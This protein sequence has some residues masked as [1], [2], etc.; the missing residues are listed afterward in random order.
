MNKRG[1]YKIKRRMLS[2]VMA[3]VMVLSAVDVSG[4]RG[5]VA[6][7]AD[8]AQ[9]EQEKEVEIREEEANEDFGGFGDLFG[10][11]DD[12]TTGYENGFAVDE[13]GNTVYQPAVLT[14]D[15][16]DVDGDDNYDEVYE[17]SNAG[18]LY[19]FANETNEKSG[20]NYNVVLTSDIVINENVLVDGVLAEDT[21]SFRKWTPICH[22]GLEYAGVFDGKGHTISGIYCANVSEEFQYGIGVFGTIN[23]SGTV[24]NLGVIDSY[25][26]D[27]YEMGAGTGAIVGCN[28]GNII[29]CYNTGVV[30]GETTKQGGICGYNYS[31]NIINCYNKGSVTGGYEHVSIGGICGRNK[32]SITDSYNTGNIVSS[33][34]E[35]KIGGVCGETN[36]SIIRC[37]NIGNVTGSG[38][39][40]IGGVV[41][42]CYD[43]GKIRNSYNTG[44]I[45]TSNIYACVGGV[46]GGGNNNALVENCYNT[47]EVTD[48]EGTTRNVVNFAST[49][50]NCYYLSDT[51]T[52]DEDG[53][54]AKNEKEFAGG[55]VA[56][57]LQGDQ[58]EEVWGQTLGTDSYPVLGGD[59]VYK[60]GTYNGCI[61]NPGEAVSYEYSNTKN[62]IYGD[63]HIDIDNDGK[64]D[65]CDAVIDG[66]GAKLAG[67]SLSLAGNIGVN[68]YMELS[69]DIV[70]DESAYMNFTLP[71]GTTSKVYVSGTHEDGTTATTDTTVK[72]NTTYYVFTCE[73]TAK[74][75]TA[76]IQAQMIG[77]N[78]EKK[79]KVYTYTVK[80]YADYILSH[81]SADEGDVSKA[82][83]QL[84]K[85][86][87][88]YG[89]AAQKYFGYKTDKLASDGLELP[90]TVFDDTVIMNNITNDANKASVTYYNT[91]DKITF[92]SAYLSLNS[93]TDLCVYVQLAEDVT[94]NENTFGIWCN[95]DQ[96]S[97]DQYEVTKVNE[98]NCYKITLHGMKASQLQEKYIFY[99]ELSDTETAKLKYG[100]TS[101]AYTVMS[102]ECDNINNIESLRE[103]VKALYAYGSCAEE[104]E[105]YKNERR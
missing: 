40:Y 57:L 74:E 75:M 59:K 6:K 55:E 100:A 56:Y 65:A 62:D 86:M 28:K 63:N 80:E 60:N 50:T 30:E 10:N 16:Y 20:Y 48:Y 70:A 87:L 4:W 25:F 72:D 95:T 84:V 19:W 14:T 47:G 92:K 36:G 67:Y 54:T 26:L 101:Y 94:V 27:K 90:E 15:K 76:D 24:K 29:N 43:G 102:S 38:E 49:V 64:C 32:G 88:N 66:I 105:Y 83:I 39:G 58:A 21:G 51:E 68:F 91:Q 85:G 13:D 3:A 23:S 37:R 103:V 89:G 77:N 31:G 44:R 81:M 69:D 17:I 71:D 78:G 33:V 98:E 73:V 35:I 52:D 11:D 2:G 22:N 12:E 7:A 61:G 93:T 42:N 79:G 96:I 18:Q 104:Y 1:K 45:S 34:E 8:E 99:V 5:V 97:K 9:I 82:T 53:T 46:C 41:G